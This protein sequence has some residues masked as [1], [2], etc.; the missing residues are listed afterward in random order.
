MLRAL[1]DKYHGGVFQYRF[2][3]NIESI[4]QDV[5]EWDEKGN[6]LVSEQ[7]EKEK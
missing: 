4:I 1:A 2:N 6:D 3:S 7:R 5:I